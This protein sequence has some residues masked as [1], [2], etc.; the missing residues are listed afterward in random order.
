MTPVGTPLTLTIG[1]TPP[2]LEPTEGDAILADVRP[3]LDR[4]SQG[5]PASAHRST[6]RRGPRS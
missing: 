2:L 6:L 3:W 5:R 4:R 1:E